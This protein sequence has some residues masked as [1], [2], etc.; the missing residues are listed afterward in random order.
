MRSMISRVAF[1]TLFL[2]ALAAASAHG[3]ENMNMDMDMGMH[4]STTEA[5]SAASSSTKPDANG[6][7]SYFAYGKHSGVILLHIALMILG[8]CIVLPAGKFSSIMPSI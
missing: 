2:A 6:P 3:D 4:A 5:V 8:W 1:A 7:M